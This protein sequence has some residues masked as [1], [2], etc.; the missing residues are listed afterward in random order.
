MHRLPPGSFDG[1][2]A[3]S[4]RAVHPDDRQNVDDALREAVRTR[5]AFRVRYRL[6]EHPD[7]EECW[8]EASGSTAYNDGTAER[9]YGLCCEISERVD[10]E[11][12][13]RNRVKQ[14]EALAEADLEQLLNDAVTTV[15]VTLAVDFVKILELLP[16]DGD[17]LLRA[18][19]GW[20]AELTGS[21]IARSE[22]HTS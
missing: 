17:L 10:L 6:A 11:I 3:S 22:E 20:K 8:L 15:A 4:L 2:I 19:F 16:G 9:M 21:I 1:T 12:E 7:Q 13:L 5:A 14:Q 18:G